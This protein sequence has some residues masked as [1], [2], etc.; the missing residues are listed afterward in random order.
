MSSSSS[1]TRM[2]RPRSA[3]VST[4]SRKGSCVV[5]GKRVGSG[6]F[7]SATET[8]GIE[9]EFRLSAEFVGKT[10]LDQLPA[11]AAPLRRLHLRAARLLP[12]HDD[13]SPVAR[14]RHAPLG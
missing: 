2:R 1:R 13:N 10:F 5:I 9:S 3:D 14:T 6:K 12:F 11:E 8:V 7:E 4:P